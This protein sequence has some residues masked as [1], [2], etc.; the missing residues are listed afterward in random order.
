MEHLPD[1]SVI[2]E[3]LLRYS[4][5]SWL[6]LLGLV[7]GVLGVLFAFEKPK[8]YVFN[9]VL[10]GR[11]LILP[12]GFENPEWLAGKD[13]LRAQLRADVQAYVPA[14]NQLSIFNLLSL[15]EKDHTRPLVITGEGG[16][17]KTRL[18]LELCRASG[19]RGILVQKHAQIADIKA[20]I[21]QAN[22]RKWRTLFV[23]DYIE[24]I[25]E[26]YDGVHQAVV[27]NNNRYAYLVTTTRV[28]NSNTKVTQGP[29]YLNAKHCQEISLNS[30]LLL[31]WRKQVCEEVLT[32]ANVPEP[33]KS[34]AAESKIP[35]IA[36]L[37]SYDYAT[38]GMSQS[39]NNNDDGDWLI[40]RLRRHIDTQ[41]SAEQFSFLLCLYPFNK[42]TRDVLPKPLKQASDTLHRQGWVS[43]T[44]SG[45]STQWHLGH[46]LLCDI[47][48][49]NF[50]ITESKFALRLEAIERMGKQAQSLRAQ[51]NLTLA[52]G[53][54]LRKL[55]METQASHIVPTL[56]VCAQQVANT[57]KRADIA[58]EVLDKCIHSLS[59]DLAEMLRV[60]TECNN[61]SDFQI[62]ALLKVFDEEQQKFIQLAVEVPQDVERLI[63]ITSLSDTQT[64]ERLS[65]TF[66]VR[67]DESTRSF[68]PDD[69]TGKYIPSLYIID[70]D[71]SVLLEQFPPDD[72]LSDKSQQWIAK[73]LRDLCHHNLLGKQLADFVII[74]YKNSLNPKV[75]RTSA[76]VMFNQSYDIAKRDNN[77]DAYS[78]LINSYRDDAN[79]E[80]RLPAVSG[81]LNQANIIAQRDNNPDAY[82]ELINSYRDDAN[83][84]VRLQAV[85]A[86][87]NQSFVIA[88]RDNNPDAYNELIHSYRDDANDE[89]RLQA[90]KAMLNQSFVI[91]KRDNNPDAY[92][93]LIHS[94]RDDAN[95]EIRLRAAKAMFNQ[96]DDIAKR[97]NNPDAYSELI[98]SYRD[99][100]NDEI[101]L[102]AVKAMFKQSNDIAQRDSNP[103]AYSE[104]INS[105]RDDANDEIRLQAAKAMFNHSYAIAE[106]DS[107]PDAYNR[108]IATYKDDTCFTIQAIVQ[109]AR[110]AQIGWLVVA[111][112]FSRAGNAAE[113]FLSDYFEV[114]VESTVV[115]FLAWLANN[116][117]ANKQRY[118][119]LLINLGER[120]TNWT[121]NEF[122]DVIETFSDNDK[123]Y[124]YYAIKRLERTYEEER[125]EEKHIVQA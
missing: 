71:A 115:A 26:L 45:K 94:Y 86:M 52:I 27:S 123:S 6:G 76:E 89:V 42:S 93:E 36:S 7:I 88:K 90:A 111:K 103:D 122:T 28:L 98:H 95:D 29:V 61:L 109:D 25:G 73:A 17:G 39:Q 113:L 78:E 34:Q 72:K 64:L 63:V 82:S 58:G 100:A 44:G 65:K 55:I 112:Q 8:Q 54:A 20:L 47:V 10:L 107:N 51:S 9:K 46:D 66:S 16:L 87:F 35:L 124:A 114:I 23:I 18:A 79:D 14:S 118:E 37:V 49:V 101:R 53:R 30:P 116:S 117:S 19:Y 97:D 2:M 69:L 12:V 31:D 120:P 56:A 50:L 22:V 119:S 43:V 13:G 121:F 91:A 108:F 96:S 84:E 3:V 60:I 102:Q 21:E 85:K 68:I 125:K 32:L 15:L 99:D 77:P 83:D 5:D 59:L 110:A 1:M 24:Q 105:Y 41:L 106:R 74:R 33:L 67:V 70:K 62:D 57:H 48:L 40:K 80:I 11:K 38:H 75:R 81:M 92:N 4:I 104:L